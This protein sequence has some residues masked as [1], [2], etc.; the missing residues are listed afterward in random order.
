VIKVEKLRVVELFAGIGAW[1]KALSNLGVDHQVLMAVEK[2]EKTIT[3]YNLIHNSDFKYID[4]NKL[5]ISDVPDCDLIC[6]SPPCQA[7]SQA[8][9]QEGFNDERGILFFEAL[10][11]IKDKQP[12]IAL[13]ENVKGLTQKKFEYEFG[14]MLKG[15]EEAGYTNHWKVIN[16]ADHN[17]PQ[18]RERVFVISIRNDLDTS[19]NF[20]KALEHRS[21]LKTVLD[22][23]VDNKYYITDHRL[24]FTLEKL[25]DKSISKSGIHKVC[26]VQPSGRGMNGWVYD[27]EGMSP[28]LTTNKSEGYKVIHNGSLRRITEYEAMRLMGFDD[29]DTDK[30]KNGG[31]K[32][33]PIYQMAGNSIN[34][35]VCE[36]LFK[37]V[38][39]KLNKT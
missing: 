9:K 35:K 3:A 39:N 10:R 27:S 31:I 23:K 5:S 16:A 28:T 24:D 8:G 34:V 11:I 15:L 37:Q 4:I 36:D 2:E 25:K 29:E 19:L 22:D 6:Y 18:I 12:K 13:M 33:S 7:F 17:S 14:S 38:L 32:M 20:P 1:A 30:L 21:Y 26:N